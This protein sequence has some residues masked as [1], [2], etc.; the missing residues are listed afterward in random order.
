[1][2][3]KVSALTFIVQSVKDSI[4]KCRATT[5][6]KTHSLYTQIINRCFNQ[7]IKKGFGLADV[8]A[9]AWRFRMDTLCH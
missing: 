4:F 9:M 2:R 5:M 8:D 7:L 6:R 1:M 3:F